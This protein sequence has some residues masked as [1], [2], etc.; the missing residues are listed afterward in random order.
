MVTHVR[1]TVLSNAVE[2][3]RAAGVYDDYLSA[4]PEAHAKFMSEVLAASWV[5]VAHAAAHYQAVD[6]LALTHAQF[7]EI[8]RRNAHRIADMIL[9]HILRQVKSL[10][11]DTIKQA[12]L[13]MG[14]I[15]DRL[16]RGG[17]CTVIELGPKD[18]AFEMHGCPFLESRSFRSGYAT[19]GQALA[20]VFCKVAYVRV[21]RPRMSH[22]HT[23]ALSMSWV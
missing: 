15:H 14:S 23:L 9:V 3:L 16:W 7:V 17:G 20:E 22:P 12:V 6:T 18:L 4:M 10:G 2:N 13:R 21:A 8:G 5:P 1:G 11:V 19:Y